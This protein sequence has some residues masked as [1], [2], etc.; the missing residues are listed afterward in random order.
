MAGCPT[1]FF[2]NDQYGVKCQLLQKWKFLCKYRKLKYERMTNDNI[3]FEINFLTFFNIIDTYTSALEY[4][5]IS[6]AK[7]H[8]LESCLKSFLFFWID[9]TWMILKYVLWGILRPLTDVAR[10]KLSHVCTLVFSP[11]QN[12][13]FKHQHLS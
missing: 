6:L 13:P 1:T 4:E 8:Q 10:L 9:F 11:L 5:I 3:I 12:G 2:D 7:N